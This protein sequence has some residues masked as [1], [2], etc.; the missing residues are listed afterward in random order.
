MHRGE[1]D[2]L[3]LYAYK[4]WQGMF[5]SYFLPRWET[6]FQQINASL[7]RGTAFDREAFAAASCEWEQRW[8]RDTMPAFSTEPTGDPVATVRELVRKWRVM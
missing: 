8:S 5:T 7:E 3:N 2:D 1:N 6:F 4:E